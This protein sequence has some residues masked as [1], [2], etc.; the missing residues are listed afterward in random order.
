MVWDVARET[1][2]MASTEK[3]GG[4]EEEEERIKRKKVKVPA[5]IC[6]AEGQ[7]ARWHPPASSPG[8]YPS[9]PLFL[10]LMFYNEISLFHIESGHFSK[11]CFCAG[12]RE[13]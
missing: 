9:R 6:K 11:D 12:P 1:V 4:E 7:C 10:R 3:R 8:E 13:G 2:R 5:S